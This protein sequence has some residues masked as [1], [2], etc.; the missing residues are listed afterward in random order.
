[1]PFASVHPT[2]MGQQEDAFSNISN[3][4]T[5]TASVMIARLC[6][7]DVFFARDQQK[8][9]FFS[10]FWIGNKKKRNFCENSGFFIQQLPF[11]LF[12]I[13]RHLF[14]QKFVFSKNILSVLIFF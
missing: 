1:M 11:F 5:K 8:K 4:N 13:I 3:S 2:T 12:L 7:S 10:Q 9:L 6:E 14:E